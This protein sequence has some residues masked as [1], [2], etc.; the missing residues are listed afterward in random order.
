MADRT[1]EKTHGF[2]NDVKSAVKGVKGAGDTIRGTVN[3]SI[4][5]A[6]NEKEGETANRAIKEKGKTEMQAADQHFSEP[7]TAPPTGGL[8]GTKA[9]A[10]GTTTG[11][12]AHSGSVGNMGSSV[13]QT[14]LGGEPAPAR[15]RY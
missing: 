11:A 12:G 6:F 10:S 3:E 8:S 1:Q 13:P 15:E 14:G 9:T 5:T 2:L 7:G 4:D